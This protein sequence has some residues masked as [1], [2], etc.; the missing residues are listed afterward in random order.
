M[1]VQL[2]ISI[3]CSAVLVMLNNECTCGAH[4]DLLH[5]LTVTSR[6]EGGG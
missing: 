3:N 2:T 6:G 1:R 4:S 5:L